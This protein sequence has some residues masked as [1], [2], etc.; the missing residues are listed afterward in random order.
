[1]NEHGAVHLVVV[2]LLFAGT[3]MLGLAVDITRVGIAY[4]EASHIAT[5][6][7]EAGEGWIDEAAARRD[8]LVV[9]QARARTAA[10]AVAAGPGRTVAVT[11]APSRVCVRVAITVRPGP[12]SLAGAGPREIAATAC[13]EPRSG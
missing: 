12:L 10:M 4:R 8:L 3:L 9:D 1:M 6:S 7:A 13:A 2:A 11:T 5:V